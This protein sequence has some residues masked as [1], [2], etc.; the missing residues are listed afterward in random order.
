MSFV[1]TKMRKSVE[2]LLDMLKE[3]ADEQKEDSIIPVAIF[4]VH[5][6]DKKAVVTPF[7]DA[8]ENAS[9][10]EALSRTFYKLFTGGVEGAAWVGIAIESYGVVENGQLKELTSSTIQ[11]ESLEKDFAE[12]P[13]SNVSEAFSV[14]FANDKGESEFLFYPY[15]R[16]DWGKAVRGKPYVRSQDES[17]AGS[18][19]EIEHLLLRF[20]EVLRMARNGEIDWDAD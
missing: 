4:K 7:A 6:S 15:S 2:D 20:Q 5:E 12:N 8:P 1:D 16:N 3:S 13:F 14:F 10:E 9:F 18:I 17:S 11:P 19:S